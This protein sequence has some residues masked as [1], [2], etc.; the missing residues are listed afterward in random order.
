M[1]FAN[2]AYAASF[3]P[4]FDCKLARSVAE[5]LIC[6]DRELAGLDVKLSKIYKA[7]KSRAAKLQF[8]NDSQGTPAQWFRK[9]SNSEWRWREKNCKNK[10]CL[11]RWYAKR[12]ALMQWIAKSEDPMG[13]FGISNIVQ[14]ADNSVI[15]TY[16]TATYQGNAFYNIYS[17]EFETMPNGGIRI[18]SDDPLIYKISDQKSY[19][20]QGGAF[21]FTSIRNAVHEIIAFGQQGVECMS[22][23][24][25]IANTS[26][27]NK[28]LSQTDF[29]IICITR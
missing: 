9:N 14:I 27:T 12:Q 15:I 16:E 3:A 22:R 11:R 23:E 13:D 18:L 28:Q 21:W 29:E 4:S 20:N 10:Q 24:L 1:L 17:Q 8:Y 6:A 5:K 19:F 7:A 2:A 25:F 26:F